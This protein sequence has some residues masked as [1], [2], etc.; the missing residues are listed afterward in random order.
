MKVL[1]MQFVHS[2][3]SIMKQ[4]LLSNWQTELQKMNMK[5]NKE[6]QLAV[7]VFYQS[8]STKSIIHLLAN[9]FVFFFLSFSVS[10]AKPLSLLLCA[11]TVFPP[12]SCNQIWPSRN[13]KH[14]LCTNICL[15][16][17]KRVQLTER[18][19]PALLFCFFSSLYVHVTVF[20]T[21][22]SLTE[23]C[24]CFGLKGKVLHTN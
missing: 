6:V 15:N 11:C 21:C 1:I 13:P 12:A 5:T 16:T 4:T 2:Q 10:E 20:Q 23:L 3:F 18:I 19:Q 17:N 9:V 14:C 7:Q 22:Y 24:V 8:A